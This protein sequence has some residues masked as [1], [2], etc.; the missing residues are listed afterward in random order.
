MILLQ[1]RALH[2]TLTTPLG[3]SLISHLTLC[4]FTASGVQKDQKSNQ[5]STAARGYWPTVC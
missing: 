3:E 5:A 4:V 2:A 1:M